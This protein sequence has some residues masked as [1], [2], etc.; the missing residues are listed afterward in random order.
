MIE[1]CITRYSLHTAFTLVDSPISPYTVLLQIRAQGL[2]YAG[3]LV[4]AS[5]IYYDAKALSSGVSSGPPRCMSD[6]R[7]SRVLYSSAATAAAAVISAGC[8][9]LCCRIVDALHTSF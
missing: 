5:N 7:I 1:Q 8:K 4:M 9:F 2:N 6:Q 3:Y